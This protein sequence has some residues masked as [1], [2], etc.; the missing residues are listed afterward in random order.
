MSLQ[1][2]CFCDIILLLYMQQTPSITLNIID[3]EIKTEPN[4][5][6]KISITVVPGVS[7]N[8]QK[9][10]TKHLIC[11]KYEDVKSVTFEKNS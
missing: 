2:M 7:M 10:L 4:K 3:V 8:L 11:G 1:C 5:Y 9:E 6:V